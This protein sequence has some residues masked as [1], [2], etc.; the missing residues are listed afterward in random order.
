MPLMPAPDPREILQTVRTIAVL[1]AHSDPTRPAHYVP[2]YLQDQGYT[3]LPVNAVTA[4]RQ[5][6]GE[7]VRA[8]L[9]ELDRPVDMVD[10]FRRP[11]ALPDH[12]ED[13]LAMRPLP[14]VV[15]LQQGI[16]N[17]AFA[18]RLEA[19]G[20]IVISDR[21]TLTDHHRFGLGPVA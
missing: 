19:H 12:L 16:R 20:I 4:G 21:C 10:V 6:F 15:W 5:L 13:I 3:I 2:A 8:S 14:R 1:G 18:A 7:T 9:A 11:D 17:D